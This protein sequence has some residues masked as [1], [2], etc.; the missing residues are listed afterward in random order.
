MSSKH[1]SRRDLLKTASAVVAA[2]SVAGIAGRRAAAADARLAGGAVAP[3]DQALGRAVE[4]KLVPHVV[5][6]AATEKGIVY[7]GA[8]GTQSMDGGPE[9][10]PDSLFW[11]ASMT[12][13]ITATA[14]MQLVEQGKLDLEQ[15]MGD[16]LPEL[17]GAEVLEGFDASGAPKLRPAKRPITLRHLL[18]HTAGFVYS[19]WDAPMGQ[20][21]KVTGIPFIGECKNESFKAPIVFDPGERWEYGINIDW[22]GQG[23]RGGERPVARGLFPRAHLRP[24]R[25]ARYG[26]LDQFGAEGAG[27][28]HV[29]PQGG[30]LARIDA[31]RDAAA[32]GVLH[33]RRRA[34]QH[35]AQLHAVPA[36]AAQRRHLQW[37]ESAEARDGGADAPEPHRRP[38][39]RHAQDASA[40]T[41]RTTPTSSPA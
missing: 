15:T 38:R 12:K 34:L 8:F 33:G 9:V 27:R 2:S 30:R 26:L 7:E 6:L 39:C 37:R 16:L 3:I 14:C 36:D 41:S 22:V 32:P 24:A 35:A 25:H 19:I 23:G 21:E 40:R 1:Q 28:D 13:A 10:S 5:A 18:T 29:Q 20:Y 17:E 31:V 11:I 4:A